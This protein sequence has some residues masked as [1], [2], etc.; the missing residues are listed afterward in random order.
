MDKNHM[1]LLPLLTIKLKLK[2][3]ADQA[4]RRAS[5]DEAKAGRVAHAMADSPSLDAALAA[6][7]KRA[8]S[9]DPE[10]NLVSTQLDRF[11]LDH[12]CGEDLSEEQP[13]RTAWT[14]QLMPAND[15]MRADSPVV[16]RELASKQSDLVDEE[17]VA[18]GVVRRTQ[19]RPTEKTESKS[20]N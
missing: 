8:D 6:L 1:A 17:A 2:Q 14:P 15:R 11:F 20:I 7:K 19:M 16:A 9:Q 5:N 13:G 10:Q 12:I 3:V 4:E 18:G